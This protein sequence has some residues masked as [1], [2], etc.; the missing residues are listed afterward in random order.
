MSLILPGAWLGVLGGGQLGRM[1]VHA[2]QA[3]GYRV[4]VLDPDE[5]SPAGHV[6]EKHVCAPYDDTEA[7]D[8]LAD[9]CPAITAEF[10]NV[11]AASLRH[12]AARVHV[13]PSAACFEIAQ[14]RAAEKKFVHALGIGVAPF[15][16]LRTAADLGHA[17]RD[18][19]PLLPGILKVARLGYDGKGQKHVV[20]AADVRAAWQ[21]FGGV[22]CVLERR[23]ALAREV[24]CIVCR[25]ADGTFATFAP[26]ENEHRDGIL[27][28]TLA[29]ARFD[30]ALADRARAHALAIAAAMDYVGVLC[31]EF[32]VLADGSLVVNEMAPRPHNSGHTTIDANVTSQFEQQARILAGLPLGDVAQLAPSVMLNLLGDLWFESRESALAREPDWPGVLRVPGARLH[33]YGKSEARRGRKMGH[34]TVLGASLEQALERA[35]RVADALGL[36]RPA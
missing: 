7:L 24:S 36:P 13:R 2:A 25:G 18:I 5:N 10:E 12:L 30:A 26:V 34:V 35:G 4:C 22:P 28:V 27:A 33:L 21:D 19:D 14:D 23:L 20:S 8:A 29:P 3:L 1:F 16:E 31:V 15:V 32:F 11:P 6:A 17:A 9:R